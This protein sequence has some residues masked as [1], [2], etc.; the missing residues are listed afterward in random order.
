MPAPIKTP[1]AKALPR[2]RLTAEFI[3]DLCTLKEMRQAGEII[4]RDEQGRT[5]A[6]FQLTQKLDVARCDR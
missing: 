4:L 2:Y 1:K 6:A 5:I 3:N